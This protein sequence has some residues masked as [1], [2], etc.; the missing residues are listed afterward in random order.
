MMLAPFRLYGIVGCPHCADAEAFLRDHRMPTEVIIA[1][2]D[3]VIKEG[4]IKLYG[5]DNYPVLVSRV[6]REVV[7]GFKRE[8][9]ERIDKA[10][11]AQLN[12]GAVSAFGGGQQPDGQNPASVPE[13]AAGA[14]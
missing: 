11:G 13:M 12:A 8:D 10:F 4:N 9:Y 6:T 5:A 3:Q 14:N 1:N 7:Q 2:D